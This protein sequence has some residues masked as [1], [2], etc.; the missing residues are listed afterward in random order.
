MTGRV[1]LVTLCLHKDIVE[2]Y[3]NTY[4]GGIKN[5]FKHYKIKTYIEKTRVLGKG[6]NR[7]D[8]EPWSI[9]IDRKD[10]NTVKKASKSIQEEANSIGIADMFK[11]M[12]EDSKKAEETFYATL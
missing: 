11:S 1:I 7:P 4:F 12:Y 5:R 9:C 6:A 2:K 10:L 8:M 3:A